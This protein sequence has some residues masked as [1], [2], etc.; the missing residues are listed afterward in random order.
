[1]TGASAPMAGA[2]DS[3]STKAYRIA[4]ERMH[5]GMAIDYSGD[6]DADFVHGMIAHHRGAIEMAEAVLE[7]GEGR[8]IR[9]LAEGVIAAQEAEVA[10]MRK[11]LLAHREGAR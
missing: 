9:T 1:M 7:H 3:A 4:G 5:A 10:E 8:E 2:A 11:W 6:A